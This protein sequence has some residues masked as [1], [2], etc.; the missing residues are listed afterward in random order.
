MKNWKLVVGASL[1]VVV[2]LLAVCYWP[3]NKVKPQTELI[4]YLHKQNAGLTAQN[5]IL[6]Q[7]N[8]L[9]A[10]DRD[11]ALHEADSLKVVS[12]SA[13]RSIRRDRATLPSLLPPTVPDSELRFMYSQA[14]ALLDRSLAN[15]ERLHN[16]AVDDSLALRKQ[17]LIE[18]NLEK[19][20]W[21]TDSLYQHEQLI[22][23][24]WKKQFDDLN[25]QRHPKCGRKCGIVLG[26]L[27]TIGTAIGIHQVQE[28]TR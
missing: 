7:A 6:A 8:A 20:L 3:D 16:I 12:D 14:I 4:D 26:V 18:D 22:S 2:V 13:T 19:Q 15:N 9:T 25:S 10:Q 28:A 1:G 5:K 23:A 21:N 11:K 17:S 24:D 27:G